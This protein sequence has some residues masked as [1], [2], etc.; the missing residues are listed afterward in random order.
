MKKVVFLLS[1]LIVTAIG[2]YS[3][4]DHT[5]K[6]APTIDPTGL[7][8]SATDR[9][10]D[11]TNCEDCASDCLSDCCLRFIRHSGNVTFAFVNPVTGNVVT[12]KMTPG[13]TDT[14][15]CAAGGYLAILAAGGSGTIE[16][17]ST[18]ATE[19]RTGV[20]KQG[21]LDFDD[22]EMHIPN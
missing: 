4:Q 17:C 10:S 18:G 21:T 15:V 3:C 20:N 11:Y 22:C 5:E 7:G 8:T 2:I 13:T 9:Y 12:R 14:V 6:L 19:T 16:V 1:S